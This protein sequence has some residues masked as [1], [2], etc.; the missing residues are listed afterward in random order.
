MINF[1]PRRDGY[2]AL[3]PFVT[4]KAGKESTHLAVEVSYELGG[5]NYFS[6]QVNRRGVYARIRPITVKDGMESFFLGDGMKV[7]CVEMKR[8]SD[9]RVT[10]VAEALDAIAP[11]IAEAYMAGSQPK[12]FDLIKAPFLS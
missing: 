2:R 5:M 9:K 1:T 12:A 6:G 11:E 8:K 7:L 10:E 3:F 4:E